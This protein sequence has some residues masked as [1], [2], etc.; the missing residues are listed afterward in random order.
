MSLVN[1]M[2]R[3]LEARRAAELGAAN[4]QR[5]VRPLPPPR[6]RRDAWL[7]LLVLGGAAAAAAAWWLARPLPA[8][9]SVPAVVAA[10]PV[11]VP[12][13]A[14]P[15]PPASPAAGE[16]VASGDAAPASL[17]AA[18][19]VVSAN[20]AVPP[21]S[22]VPVDTLRMAAVLERPPALPPPVSA[23]TTQAPA[24]LPQAAAPV[25]AAGARTEPGVPA[26]AKSEVSPRA[27]PAL[28][29]RSPPASIEK[30]VVAA[31]PRERAEIEY[32]RGQS[33]LAAGQGNAAAEAFR[34][35]LH[36]DASHVP[37]RQGLLRLLLENQRME[38][39]AAL[40]GEGLEALPAQIGWA[41]TLAR[42]AVEKGDLAGAERVLDRSAPHARTHPEY[43]GF[44][45]HVLVRQGKARA[46]VERYELATRLAAAEGR[47][48]FGLGQA[49]EGDGRAPEA[50]EAY[51]RALASGNLNAELAQLAEARLK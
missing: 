34:A 28:A 39:A 5:E 29:P 8:P 22:A 41:M 37:A 26:P 16:G 48:W 31:S 23:A 32:R 27:E 43:V 44:Q 25:P 20:P 6:S 35:A 19:A 2:L 9:A 24:A 21:S 30:T 10:P 4:L 3:D 15:P 40:L 50:R 11:A 38:E 14:A 51:R 49:L 42:L 7:A 47:W 18:T 46:A 17:P 13:P 1:D 33:A 36:Q 12:I 45:G